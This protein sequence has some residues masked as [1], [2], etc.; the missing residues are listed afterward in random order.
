MLIREKIVLVNKV[1]LIL[2]VVCMFYGCRSSS[3]VNDEVH[4]QTADAESLNYADGP[5]VL[6]FSET[7]RFPENTLADFMY[8]VP[9]ISPVPVSA[10]ISPNNTQGGYLVSY[11]S[12]EIRDRFHVACE[13]R[14]KGAGFYLNKFDGDAMV[15]WNTKF[16]GNK[17]VLEN[18]L[19]YIKFEGTG[20]G[21][22]EARGTITGAVMTV[23]DVEV[24]FNARGGESPVTAGL[25]DVDITKKKDGH[26]ISYN[27]KVARITTLTFN[28]SERVPRMGLEISA[29][30]K[31]EESLGMWAHIKG[32]LGNFFIEPI[33]IDKLGNET[34]LEFGLGLYKKE[35]KFTFPK[36]KNLKTRN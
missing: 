1:F 33:E 8:F 15:E 2:A 25:Y 12:D 14:M 16:S 11:E 13:F 10:V 5:T 28:R 20:Y 26:Y 34:M 32:F 21:R 18:I 30:G 36:A 27:H 9:L 22:I 17:K 6:L 24:H 31:N 23:E 4:H 7:G 19:D 35:A 3:L 29:V